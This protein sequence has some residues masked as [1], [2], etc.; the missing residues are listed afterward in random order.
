LSWRRRRSITQ[1]Q[2]RSRP[3]KSPFLGAIDLLHASALEPNV[4]EEAQIDALIDQ[5]QDEINTHD[6]HID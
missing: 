3:T 2:P 4:F 1:P 6:A 5:I